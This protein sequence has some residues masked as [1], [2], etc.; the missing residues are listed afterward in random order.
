VSEH[1]KSNS[2]AGDP[3]SFM[4]VFLAKIDEKQNDPIFNDEQLIYT[5]LDLFQAG[6]DTNSNALTFAH[7]YLIMHPHVQDRVHEELDAVIS[8]GSVITA[9]MKLKLPYCMATILETLRYSSLVSLTPYREAT[10]DIKFR[11][12]IIKKGT[13]IMINIQAMHFDEAVWGDPQVFR[14]ERFTRNEDGVTVIDK[15]KADLIMSFGGGRRICLGQNLAETTI[16]MYFT[17]MFRNFKF[18]KVCGRLTP[19]IVPHL[20]LVYAPKPFEVKVMQRQ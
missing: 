11:N 9:E 14:P 8:K 6:G 5:L 3:Q 19:S 2:C 10:Q 13:A 20:G 4:D 18:E 16:F 15:E 12:Y 17:T 1:R 7:L